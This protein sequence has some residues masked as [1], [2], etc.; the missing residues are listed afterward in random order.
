MMDVVIS[1]GWRSSTGLNVMQVDRGDQPQEVRPSVDQFITRHGKAE[2]TI[3][4]VPGG[5]KVQYTCAGRLFGPRVCLYEAVHAEARHA[6]WDVMCRVIRATDDEEA[7][8]LAG[9]NASHWL[10]EHSSVY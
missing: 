3:T 9:R 5:W 2:I 7:G 4:V 8:V 1:S 6:A 10:M